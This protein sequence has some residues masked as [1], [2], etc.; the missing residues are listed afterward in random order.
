MLL[1]STFPHSSPRSSAEQFQSFDPTR[2]AE[3]NQFIKLRV[4]HTCGMHNNHDHDYQGTFFL[5]MNVVCL[6]SM[7]QPLR[8][9][10]PRRSM[11]SI[12][13]IQSFI[14]L[15]IM[16]TSC[17][18]LYVEADILNPP[19]WS[20]AYVSKQFHSSVETLFEIINE[21]HEY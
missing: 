8:R 18:H 2:R 7:G 1:S 9:S 21:Y 3:F 19:C 5:G 20:R 10:H 14:S 15:M 16:D 12:C 13:P 6:P 11:P 17:L 4:L